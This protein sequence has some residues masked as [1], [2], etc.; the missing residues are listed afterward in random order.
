MVQ[1][2]QQNIR[3]FLRKMRGGVMKT[4][5][6]DGSKAAGE[7]LRKECLLVPGID[8]EEIFTDSSEALDYVVSNRVEF[9]LMEVELEPM[10]GIELARKMRA[11]YPDMIIIFVTAQSGYTLEALEV[12]ADY[13]VIKPY[14]EDDILDALNRAKL[15]AKRLHKRIYIRTFGRF[16]VFIDGKLVNFPNAK[17]KELLAVCVDHMGGDVSM[18]EAIDKLWPDRDYDNRVKALYRKAVIGIHHLLE[19]YGVPEVFCNHRGGCYLMKEMVECDFFDYLDNHAGQD[20]P[21]CR[22]YMFEYSWAEETNAWLQK[23]N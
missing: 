3:I 23:K 19:S 20:A 13:F 2:R 22:E 4:I 7:R 15:L 18:E 17:S 16:D 12:R 11:V 8:V 21:C 9:V 10:N 6:V 14:E 1:L 5:I